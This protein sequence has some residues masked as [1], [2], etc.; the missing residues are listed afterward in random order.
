M[1]LP[2]TDYPVVAIT[3]LA[4]IIWIVELAAIILLSGIA[5][6]PGGEW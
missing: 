4:A 5:F 2:R 3:L 6:I 1:N